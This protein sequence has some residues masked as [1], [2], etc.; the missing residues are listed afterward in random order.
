MPPTR[1]KR[2]AQ[3]A[4]LKAVLHAAARGPPAAARRKKVKQKPKSQRPQQQLVALERTF[5]PVY[6][7]RPRTIPRR[8]MAIPRS[9]TVSTMFDAFTNTQP[10]PDSMTFGNFTPCRSYFSFGLTTEWLNPVASGSLAFGATTNIAT[11]QANRDVCMWVNWQP[12]GV[13]AILFS[14]SINGPAAVQMVGAPQF[15]PTTN[16]TTTVYGPSGMPVQLRSMRTSVRITNTTP[17]TKRQGGVASVVIPQNIILPISTGNGIGGYGSTL[18]TVTAYSGFDGTP[19][20]P[21]AATYYGAISQSGVQSITPLL[22]GAGA[23]F[24]GCE[25]FDHAHQWDLPPASYIGF[26]SYDAWQRVTTP[27]ASPTSFNGVNLTSTAGIPNAMTFS[28][29]TNFATNSALNVSNALFVF[30]GEGFA[31]PQS[32]NIEIATM[33]AARFPANTLLANSAVPG[34]PDLDNAIQRLSALVGKLG[35]RKVGATKRQ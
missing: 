22:N 13:T 3:R 9:L 5:Q 31:D 28:D 27:D 29:L 26:H 1:A 8:A 25:E 14:T 12:S 15:F 7:T 35:P 6:A 21:A 33:D 34:K 20:V 17:Q 23:H 19:A 10:L 16:S 32:Y 11:S 30:K 24:T 2:N 4:A 18:A